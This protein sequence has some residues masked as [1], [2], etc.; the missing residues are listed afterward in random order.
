MHQHSNRCINAST[1]SSVLASPLPPTFLDTYSLSTSS[2]G[3]NALCMVI[4]FL[5]LW[6]ICLS[7]SLVYF[8]SGPEYLMRITARVSI[9]LIRFLRHSFVSS[10]FLFLLRYS[11]LI[12]FFHLHLFDG[13]SFKDAQV[14]VR[15]LFSE[16]SN[17][18]LIW[19]FHSVRQVSFAAFHY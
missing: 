4:S 12:F 2:L 5:V 1:L 15:F 17:L 16:S 13:V 3:Y 7:S 6:S 8:K 11:F 10:S 18:V 19:Q 14:F 9:P